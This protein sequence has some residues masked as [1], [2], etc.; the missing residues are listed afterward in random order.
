MGLDGHLHIA[1]NNGQTWSCEMIQPQISAR[2]INTAHQVIALATLDIMVL[3]T[4]DQIHLLRLEDQVVLH[5]VNAENIQPRSVRCRVPLIKL[6]SEISTGTHSLIVTYTERTTG[7]CVILSY[8]PREESQGK[9][10]RLDRSTK[11]RKA[12]G[13][14]TAQRFQK[15][16]R[17]PGCWETL[18]DGTVVGIRRRSAAEN[19]ST[20]GMK[21][22][23]RRFPKSGQCYADPCPWEMWTAFPGDRL[24]RDETRPLLR[25]HESDNHLLISTVGP[26]V[27]VGLTSVAFGFGNVVKV[28]TVGGQQRFESGR[29]ATRHEHWL[30]ASRRRKSGGRSRQR[31]GS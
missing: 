5:T 9:E 17:N 13:W 22:L 30:S 31:S 1:V 20:N 25:P 4:T 24:D 10:I 16:I 23:R 11:G 6:G 29:D 19:T 7:D 27:E 8:V 15:R 12:S 21:G 18:C 26:Q 2:M 14:Q 3:V 28:V